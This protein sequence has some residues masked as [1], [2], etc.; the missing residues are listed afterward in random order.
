MRKLRIEALAEAPLSIQLAGWDPK[1]WLMRRYGADLGATFIDINKGCPARK[2]TEKLVVPMRDLIGGCYNGGG[3]WGG[4]D[5][6]NI[7]NAPWLG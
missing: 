7:E 3:G 1:L 2:V 5:T 4:V 6:G